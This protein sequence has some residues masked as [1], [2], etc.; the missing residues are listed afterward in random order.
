MSRLNVLVADDSLV[1]RMLVKRAVERLYAAEI[2]EAATGSDALQLVRSVRFDL[3]IADFN[4]PGATGIDVLAAL[5]AVAAPGAPPTPFILVSAVDPKDPCLA[6]ATADPACV[7]LHKPYAVND[8]GNAV[9]TALG[10]R[11]A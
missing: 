11:T 6:P 9:A 7:M 4:M 5:R 8:L 2:V 10:K 3:V 1:A